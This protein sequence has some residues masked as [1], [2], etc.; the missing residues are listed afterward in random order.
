MINKLE[1]ALGHQVSFLYNIIDN[2]IEELETNDISNK[3]TK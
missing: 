3:K 1:K 2:N